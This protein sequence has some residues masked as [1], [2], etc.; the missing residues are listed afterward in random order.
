MMYATPPSGSNTATTADENFYSDTWSAG[1]QIIA[2]T[3]TVYFWV[4]SSSDNIINLELFGG[5]TSLGTKAW[6]VNTGGAIQL[7]STTFSTSG[8]PFAEG[9]RLR[10]YVDMPG[11]FPAPMIYWDGDYSSSRLVIPEVFSGP[12]MD[13]ISTGFVE[14]SSITISHTTSGTDRLMLVGVSSNPSDLETVS[15]ITYNG[16]SLSFIGRET[17]SNDAQVEI[18]SLIAPD[19]GTYDVVITFSEGIRRAAVAGVTTFTGVDQITPLGTF[20]SVSDSSPGPATV[21]V[22]S[23]TNELVFD[24]VACEDCDGFMVGG[25]QT[26][27]W[28]VLE[29]TGGNDLFGAGSTEPGAATITMSWTLTT[30]ACWAIGAVPIKPSGG[31]PPSVDSVSTGNT[32]R[33]NLTISH[34]TSGTNR[35]IMVGIA[36][37]N[38]NF[39]TVG[40]VTYNGVL[41]SLVGSAAQADDARVEIWSLVAPDT[42]THDVVITFSA[43]LI[44]TAVVGVT[45]FTGVDQVTPLGT[46]ASNS[47]LQTTPATVNVSSAANELVFDTVAG[48]ACGSLTVG[49]GQTQRWNILTDSGGPV[50]FGVGSTEWGAATVTMSW[51]VGDIVSSSSW[52]IGAVPIK[53]P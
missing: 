49:A 52:A 35:L 17:Y 5:S 26:Q 12:S 21:N 2:G 34:T 8:Y 46:F 44:R 20:A 7:E 39:E 25:G 32:D 10:L 30:S 36:L 51:D 33:T 1:E 11:G 4:S 40:S 27:R 53:P 28:N 42:G 43:E 14:P 38:D 48:E 23:T 22:T 9:E 6:T 3:T 50:T 19:V 37:N 15:S 13:S 47:G 41:L 45:T 16:A 18:W 24:T 31:L 29:A